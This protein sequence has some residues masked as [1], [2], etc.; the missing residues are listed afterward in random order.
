MHTCELFNCQ[1]A[2]C[3]NTIFSTKCWK[4]QSHPKFHRGSAIPAYEQFTASKQIELQFGSA[5]RG[6]SQLAQVRV[7][8]IAHSSLCE[9]I[10][11]V[12]LSLS[13]LSYPFPYV[14][15]ESGR[16]IYTSPIPIPAEFGQG[17]F[18]TGIS[19]FET[20]GSISPH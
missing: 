12:G 17:A 15:S 16:S 19:T 13:L 3:E 9:C 1:S 5:G 18:P 8:L 10:S 2:C 14:E 11:L 4:I 20:R 7:R 6:V